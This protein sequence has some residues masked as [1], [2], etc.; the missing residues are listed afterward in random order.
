MK[1]IMLGRTIFVDDQV[2]L[3]INSLLRDKVLTTKKDID[4]VFDKLPFLPIDTI[5]YDGKS[6]SPNATVSLSALRITGLDTF[7]SMKALKTLSK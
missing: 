7:K 1:R 3:A 5:L 6:A 2:D 4:L